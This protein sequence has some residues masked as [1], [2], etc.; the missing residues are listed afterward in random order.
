VQDA[1]GD[2]YEIYSM[3]PNDT[4]PEDIYIYPPITRKTDFL[5]GQACD[6]YW[7]SYIQI[8]SIQVDAIYDEASIAPID[9]V[10]IG[11][12][13]AVRASEFLA[14]A[15]HPK[16]VYERPRHVALG[17]PGYRP[18]RLESWP[19]GYHTR[20]PIATDSAAVAFADDSIH[21]DIDG[22]GRVEVVLDVIATFYSPQ[23]GDNG[24]SG[25]SF[26]ASLYQYDTADTTW[27]TPVV[28]ATETV[29]EVTVKTYRVSTIG[30]SYSPGFD[31]TAR[32]EFVRFLYSKGIMH[33]AQATP[34]DWQYAHRE[35][36]LYPED[37][38]LIQRVVVTIDVAAAYTGICR[39]EVNASYV[40]ASLEGFD[41]EVA[42]TD[43]LHLTCVGYSA[44][45]YRDV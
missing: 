29:A 8:R 9:L 37:Y 11:A 1:S 3:R 22:T 2:R 34:E 23:F 39:L 13:K 35:G 43:R 18:T 26:D 45:Q 25:W 31:G 33:D 20:W 41:N 21:I 14:H 42:T 5:N 16:T 32:N 38:A 24:Q 15:I 17:P 12:R 30:E 36:L 7:L 4:S 40:A 28:I 27:G 10:A 19:S 44:Y 6:L